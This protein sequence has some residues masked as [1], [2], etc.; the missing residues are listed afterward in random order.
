MGS[1]SEAAAA[2]SA[3][4]VAGAA[5]GDCV[6]ASERRPLLSAGSC[7]PGASACGEDEQPV[8]SRND[9]SNRLAL[10]RRAPL[11]VRALGGQFVQVVKR[12][13]RDSHA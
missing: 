8:R 3:A 7:A 2:D 5:A 6:A 10:V 4:G 1:S 11:Q 12:S 13:V 9:G